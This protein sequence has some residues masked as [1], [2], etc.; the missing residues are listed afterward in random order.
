ME[1]WTPI[2]LDENVNYKS[3]D[4]V[5]AEDWNNL[6]YLIRVQGNNNADGVMFARA[7]I[8]LNTNTINQHSIELNKRVISNDVKYIRLNADNVIETSTDGVNWQST[9]SSGHV[10]YDSTQSY[11]QRSR[12]KFLNTEI[13]DDGTYTI[14]N[15]LKGETGEKGDKGDKGDTGAKGETGDLGPRGFS[16]VPFVSE[17]GIISWA[18]EEQPIIP[19][20]VNIRGPQGRQGEQGEIG[21]TGP[22]GPQG[23]QGPQGEQ[24]PRGLQ[25][26]QGNDGLTGATGPQGPMGPQGLP[27]ERGTDGHS[28]VIQ[29]IY[30]TLAALKQAFPTGNEYAY[31]VTAENKEIF[32]WSELLSDWVTL[33][34]IQGPVGPQGPTG[35]QGP[36]GPTGATGAQGPQGIQGIQGIQGPQGDV[37]P[38]G[39]KG[40]TGASGSNGKSAYSYATEGGYSGSEGQFASDLSNVADIET[41]ITD[42]NKHITS[43][44]RTAWNAK[45]NKPSSGIP[46]TDLASA[47]RTSLGKADTAL[48][49]HQDI[50]GKANKPTISTFT[51]LA[52]GWE[53]T[54][55]IIPDTSEVIDNESLIDIPYSAFVMN[56]QDGFYG[57][58]Y[59]LNQ[60]SNKYEYVYNFDG[61]SN[62]FLNIIGEVNELN[63]V[64]VACDN[65]YCDGIVDPVEGIYTIRYYDYG[66]VQLALYF[67]EGTVENASPPTYSFESQYPSTTN[68][69]EI[70]LDASATDEMV[71]AWS[72]AKMV[73]SAS[74]NT[75]T[76]RGD[77]PTI[78]ITCI[79]KRTVK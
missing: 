58:V 57:R 74:S 63:E 17:A 15:G 19:N 56:L 16:L 11:P 25:G 4:K 14:I 52:S 9:G 60:D 2:K 73:G 18:L 35:A 41:H 3:K 48:Q 39:P 79:L 10:V 7:D 53:S 31:Q 47:V 71:E 30:P 66:Y 42:T 8:E 21:P 72:N 54:K 20:P 12:L 27:G 26:P 45:Y 43:S 6:W 5:N 65:M 70:E 76:A 51:L 64:W 67:Y 49:K 69:I 1:D 61:N 78:D 34:P 75:L 32:I 46:K 13:R 38:Q 40:D 37:G 50:S 44:E 22:R 59:K 23:L 24:G 55:T 28:F 29:D 68:N 77:V 33:G 36:I 62:E